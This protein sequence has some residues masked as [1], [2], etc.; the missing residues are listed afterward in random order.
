MTLQYRP[1]GA[2]DAPMYAPDRD[3][4]YNFPG[5]VR[6]AMYGLHPDHQEALFGDYLREHG[7]TDADLGRAAVVTAD[8]LRWMSADDVPTA[9]AALER[10]GFFGLPF[11][12]QVAI[13]CRIGQVMLAAYYEGVRDTLPMGAPTP[14]TIESLCQEA[15]ELSRSFETHAQQARASQAE[16]G[17][18]RAPQ[19]DDHDTAPTG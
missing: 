12:A 8:T 5:L 9:T 10:S 7:V 17:V 16:E 19:T 13:C 3:I 6:V 14:A 1:K 15:R 2:D 18:S 11:A 4:A